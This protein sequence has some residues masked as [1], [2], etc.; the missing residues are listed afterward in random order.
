MDEAGDSSTLWYPLNGEFTSTRSLAALPTSFF[1]NTTLSFSWPD[2]VVSHT[3]AGPSPV[4]LSIPMLWKGGCVTT[5]LLPD[6]CPFNPEHY[7]CQPL[8][9]VVCRLRLKSNREDGHFRKRRCTRGGKQTRNRSR[10]LLSRA[11]GE[12]ADRTLQAEIPKCWVMLLVSPWAR[13]LTPDI[14]SW[15]TRVDLTEGF[16]AEGV[17]GTQNNHRRSPAP[18]WDRLSCDR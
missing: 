18:Q 6:I 10:S 7:F 2:C 8:A 15:R 9:A 3:R 4:C 17:S 5:A 16:R 14:I 11:P 12:M 1:R 13:P